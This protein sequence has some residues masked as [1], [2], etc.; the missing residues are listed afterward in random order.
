MSIADRLR[1]VTSPEELDQ[2]LREI[3]ANP[4]NRWKRTAILSYLPDEFKRLA[5][6]YFQ[7]ENLQPPPDRDS[8]FV[9]VLTAVPIADA[10]EKLSR[11]NAQEGGGNDG[12]PQAS[13]RF[14][15]PS[16]DGVDCDGSRIG[17]ILCAL[18]EEHKAAEREAA[19]RFR[20]SNGRCIRTQAHEVVY[21][22]KWSSDPDLFTP[23]TLTFGRRDY[24]A[25]VGRQGD[26]E[27]MFEL[28]VTDDLGDEIPS[29]V[30]RLD[31]TFLL[32]ALF[33]QLKEADAI[34]DVPEAAAGELGRSPD[35]SVP[36]GASALDNLPLNEL[37][38]RAIGVVELSER[39][40]VWG[41]PGTGKTLTLG[42]LIAKLTSK[43]K[44]VLVV[45]PYNIAVDEAALASAAAGDW[46]EGEIVRFGRIS[47]RVRKTRLDLDSLLEAAATRSGL[48]EAAQHVL[49]ALKAE[50]GDATLLAPSTV[51]GVLEELGGLRIGLRRKGNPDLAR[52]VG[53]C[54]RV[55]HTVFRS[56][57]AS[58]LSNA[59]LV[60]TTFSLFTISPLIRQ[61]AFDHVL[62]DEASVMRTPEAVFLMALNKCPV[63]FF[64]DPRQLPPIVHAKSRRVDE[65]FRPNPFNLAHI[66]D[67]KDAVGACVMLK[68]QFRM[69]PPIRKLVSHFFYSDQLVDGACPETG[70]LALL[71]T[72]ETAAA[73]TTR[74]VRMRPSKVNLVH[75]SIVMQIVDEIVGRHRE[76]R[77]LVLSP[78]LAQRR[79]YSAESAA[80]SGWQKVRFGTV[81]A[82]Q[83]TESDIVIL[84]TV[85]APGRAR[86]RFL[87][88]TKTPELPNLLNVG[89][90][91][92]R[93]ALL[94]VA[95]RQA[96]SML[97]PDRMLERIVE[98]IADTAEHHTVPQDL[99]FGRQASTIAGVLMA[100]ARNK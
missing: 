17:R 32:R 96:I 74:Y 55:I 93:L 80:R 35:S 81:H 62:V 10:L 51:R 44:R 40:Y 39:A 9:R 23:G 75:R 91:R 13:E 8:A 87:D 20:L 98:W 27:K 71:D 16:L 53:R 78:F 11:L 26:G 97:L 19:H 2:L 14:A 54:V 68:E 59:R 64:G 4:Q 31:P 46:H 5:A 82:S 49:V 66:S 48:L 76:L 61:T 29:A 77:V 63:S 15:P 90:S 50:R 36:I 83:G 22:F 1:S 34:S 43:G 42:H 92:A 69:A 57:E 79:D 95:H 67:P 65:W 84:D 86:P 52:Q 37:Q 33:T 58:I 88:E 41:P 7:G 100:S 3:A 30:F 56:P 89:L 47:E 28:C 73:M 72:S 12:S 85:I 24:P 38:R 60:A 6:T 94:V 70:V 99:R 25:R 21:M 45:S 18:A